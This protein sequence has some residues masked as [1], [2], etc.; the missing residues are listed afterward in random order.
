MKSYLSPIQ[1]LRP[2]FEKSQS[3]SI[4]WLS[5]AHTTSEAT[6]MKLNKDLHGT[7]LKFD[8]ERFELLIEKQIS[9][10]GCNEE[11]I[12]KRG[13]EL[14]D[15]CDFNFE[16]NEVFNLN[17]NSSGEFI[18]KRNLIYDNIVTRRFLEF[19][20]NYNNGKQPA[21]KIPND[22]IHV[23]CSGYVSPSPAQKLVSHL[24]WGKKVHVTHA[25]HMGCYASIPAIRM[26]TGFNLSRLNSSQNTQAMADV[27]HS[28]LCTLHFN[29]GIHSPEQLVVQSLFADGYAKYS[30]FSS[31]QNQSPPENACFEI[32]TTMEM[33]VP[34]SENCM[35]WSLAKEGLKMTL[36]R[37]VPEKIAGSLKDFLEDLF[38]SCGLGLPEMLK[39]AFFAIHPG[40]PKI[41]DSCQTLLELQPW[42]VKH[43]RM[44]LNE[45]GNMSS[46]TLP[47]VWQK[48]E[49]EVKK[50]SYIVS[51]AFGPGLT[52]CGSV[53][54]KF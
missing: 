20:A 39:S 28:E 5:K 25:Y 26:A 49:N 30:V 15:F 50:N 45:F 2:E 14:K 44:V 37:N 12:S 4:R 6:L 24:N 52:I 48:M 8:A 9:R 47:H 51:L 17:V 32:L 42:Q 53:F 29:P 27:V 16:S 18:D 38:K 1:I 7:E 10:F 11:K 46:A 31:I 22:L 35:S 43:S 41:I 36:A 13:H 54:K 23:T 34:D 40:G 19:Y 3:D 21:P 33:I